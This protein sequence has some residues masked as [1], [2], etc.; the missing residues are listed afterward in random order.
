MILGWIF[1]Q[2]SELVSGVL[3]AI[4]AGTFLYVATVEKIQ[5]EFEDKENIG[6]KIISMLVGIGFV[7]LII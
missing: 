7:C 6:E 2:S 3:G 4:S 5:S 1:S